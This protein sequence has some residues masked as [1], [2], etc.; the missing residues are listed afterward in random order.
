MPI[1]MFSW[2]VSIGYRSEEIAL[3]CETCVLSCVKPQPAL[4][5]DTKTYTGASCRSDINLSLIPEFKI[6]TMNF[7]Y[8]CLFV[9]HI[10]R[11]N[12]DIAS[13]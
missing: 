6:I 7:S 10:D 9:T 2:T 13:I 5:E 8:F 3:L 11:Y 12:P 1:F 4:G